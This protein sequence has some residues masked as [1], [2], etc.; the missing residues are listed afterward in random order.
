M[1]PPHLSPNSLPVFALVVLG[2]VLLS[3]RLG[4]VFMVSAA[5]GG[6]TRPSAAK[7]DNLSKAV[8]LYYN[9]RLGQHVFS[10]FA[11]NMV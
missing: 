10:V 8:N 3:H 5:T 6:T 11:V 9:C 7:I 4:Q 1:L 2:E